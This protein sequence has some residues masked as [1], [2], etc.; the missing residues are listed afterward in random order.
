MNELKINPIKPLVQVPDFSLYIFILLV[1]CILFLIT[2]IS[3]YLYKKI[4]NKKINMQKVYKRELKK[5]EIKESK[6]AAYSITKYALL[7]LKNET[8]TILAKELIGEL[9]QYKYKKTSKEFN[10]KTIMLLNKFKDTL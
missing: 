4:K 9:N 5:I 8:Q 7:I 10:D 2:Y 3:Y 6:S 1:L